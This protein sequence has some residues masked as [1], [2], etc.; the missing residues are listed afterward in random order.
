MASLHWHFAYVYD[1]NCQTHRLVEPN[2]PTGSK[3]PQ[4]SWL[5]ESAHMYSQYMSARPCIPLDINGLPSYS[6]RY[7]ALR[8]EHQEIMKTIRA[9]GQQLQDGS[10]DIFQ[11]GALDDYWMDKARAVSEQMQEETRMGP[12]TPEEVLQ[13]WGYSAEQAALMF[14]QILDMQLESRVRSQCHLYKRNVQGH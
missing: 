8:L 9:N 2:A 12:Q 13:T 10:I 7:Y 3:M 1:C 5:G 4:T 11:F 6:Y 14:R